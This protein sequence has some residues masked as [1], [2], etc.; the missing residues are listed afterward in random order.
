M[1]KGCQ[2][3]WKASNWT[4]ENLLDRYEFW[5]TFHQKT[6]NSKWSGKTMLKSNEVKNLIESGHFVK[7]F[8]KLPK[9]LKGWTGH[10]ATEVKLMLDLIDEYSV[11]RP[12]PED[13]FY[14]YHVDTDQAYF[15]LA[16]AGTGKVIQLVYR[17]NISI[18]KYLNFINHKSCFLVK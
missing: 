15:G 9:N 14:K 13:E 11:P 5:P 4:I 12:M 2:T 6:I 18:Y 17:K 10:K 3:E 16:T 8:P 7:I 1:V